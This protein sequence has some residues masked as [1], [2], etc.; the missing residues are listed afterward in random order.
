M[1]EENGFD[2]FR[3]PVSRARHSFGDGG[4]CK[5]QGALLPSAIRTLSFDRTN[6]ANG[7]INC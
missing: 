2:R 5:P 3:L 7:A 6:A 1:K 4:W